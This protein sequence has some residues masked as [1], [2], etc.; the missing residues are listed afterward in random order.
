MEFYKDLSLLRFKYIYE[1]LLFTV[2]IIRQI[3]F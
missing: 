3:G 1:F 2:G